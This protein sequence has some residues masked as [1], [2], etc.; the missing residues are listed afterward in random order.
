ML[1]KRK[2]MKSPFLLLL[3]FLFT[4]TGF[5]QKGKKKNVFLVVRLQSDRYRIKSETVNAEGFFD[6]HYEPYYK[7]DAEAGNPYASDVYALVPFVEPKGKTDRN[8]V[9][10]NFYYNRNDTSTTY[11]NYFKTATEAL[12]FFSNTGWDLFTVITE[13]HSG[14]PRYTL[15]NDTIYYF[16]KEVE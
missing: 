4:L 16:K 3:A 13:T 10:V 8:P 11:F 1:R 15:E 6:W 7:I 14:Y 5:A 2:N 12:L 9:G